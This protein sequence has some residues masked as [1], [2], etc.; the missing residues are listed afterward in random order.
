MSHFSV[1]YYLLYQPPTICLAP[2]VASIVASGLLNY[3]PMP[4]GSPAT[5][6]TL[7]NAM[8]ILRDFQ[9]FLDM[10]SPLIA[11]AKKE[12]LNVANLFIT[13]WLGSPEMVRQLRRVHTKMEG[14]IRLFLATLLSY[15]ALEA[16][17]IVYWSADES[18]VFVIDIE[19]TDHKMGWDKVLSYCEQMGFL[20]GEGSS[21][22]R[23]HSAGGLTIK[24]V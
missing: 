24:N 17:T 15:H 7:T 19:D 8:D 2:Q 20:G 21:R 11:G 9:D 18:N 1:T 5:E 12:I 10:E 14:H 6:M 16:K 23:C 22:T 4:F 13:T 3:R